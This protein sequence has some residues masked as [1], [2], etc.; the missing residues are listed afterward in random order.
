MNKNIIVTT[1][2]TILL[3]S[4]FNFVAIDF[5]KLMSMQPNQ[6]NQAAQQVCNCCNVVLNDPSIQEAVNA[7]KLA[8]NHQLHRQCLENILSLKDLSCPTC[9]ASIE[10]TAEILAQVGF[11]QEEL[12]NRLRKVSENFHVLKGASTELFELSRL[13]SFHYELQRPGRTSLRVD[14][15]SN[16]PQIQGEH[17]L[18]L[19]LILAVI[20]S[21]FRDVAP[22]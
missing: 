14:F 22:T 11:T 7:V 10:V 21:T 16:R 12:L 15:Q 18:F 3:A 2:H 5:S 8:C 6:Q 9:Q 4:A 19:M 13:R 17:V 1:V 20:F